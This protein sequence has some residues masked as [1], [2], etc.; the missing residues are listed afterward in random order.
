MTFNIQ[1]DGNTS[2]TKKD[3]SITNSLNNRVRNYEP[4]CIHFLNVEGRYPGTADNDSGPFFE[5]FIG[6]FNAGSQVTFGGYSN[7]ER[8]RTANNK[9]PGIAGKFGFI[10]GAN[11][12]TQDGV[13]ADRKARL[14]ATRRAGQSEVP[15]ITKEIPPNR[16]D[17]GP[18]FWQLANSGEVV[19]GT[20]G[21]IGNPGTDS[22]LP[23][24][25]ENRNGVRTL[26]ILNVDVAQYEQ[27]IDT[28]TLDT[29]LENFRRPFYL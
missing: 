13:M 25:T 4:N 16:S 5:A 14:L 1:A 23:S 18:A 24:D 21:A 17:V 8:W 7:F 11:Y 28:T 26:E 20:G 2:W 3:T 19:R 12:P 6:R 15:P 29:N 9:Y 27:G 10:T 22:D